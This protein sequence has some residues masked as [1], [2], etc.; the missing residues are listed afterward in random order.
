M[1]ERP[2]AQRRFARANVDIAATYTVPAKSV[3]L[4]AQIVNL[5]G[6]GIRLVNQ[7]DLARE[8]L[9]DVRFRLPS[10]DEL[11]AQGKVVL[12][13]YDAGVGAF[14][15]GIA[16]TRIAPADQ[17]AIVAYVESIDHQAKDV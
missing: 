9:L 13:F 3:A 5:G 6:G 16:F 4:P 10:G 17:A 14:A 1:S 15:H 12:S 8:S 7:E 2:R 11:S